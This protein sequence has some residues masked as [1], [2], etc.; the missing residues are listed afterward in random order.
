MNRNPNDPFR[1]SRVEAEG[2]NTAHRILAGG[3]SELNDVT[4]AA[5]NPYVSNPARS[6]WLTGFRNAVAAS[7]GK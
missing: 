5:C 7:E 1:L 3:T 2:W 4:V 6:R